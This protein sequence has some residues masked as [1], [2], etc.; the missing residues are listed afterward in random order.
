MCKY[1]FPC[2]HPLFPPKIKIEEDS[3]KS[4]IAYCIPIISDQKAK[5][6]ANITIKYSYFFSA[7]A[8]SIN[9]Q[10]KINKVKLSWTQQLCSMIYALTIN[11]KPSWVRESEKGLI[12]LYGFSEKDLSIYSSI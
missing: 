7:N 11:L 10:Q 6:H 12:T 9:L 8:S 3:P 5:K 1:L 4:H 2:D